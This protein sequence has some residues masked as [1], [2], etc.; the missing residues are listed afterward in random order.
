VAAYRNQVVADTAKELLDLKKIVPGITLDLRY[1]T[2]NNFTKTIL[3]KTAP[4]TYM[5]T[6]PARTLARIQAQLRLKNYGIKVFD[7]YRPHAATRLMWELVKDERYVASPVKGSNH[8][9]G[10]AIDMTLVDLKTG[11]ELDMGTG[12]DNFTDTAHHSFTG[13]S[14]QVL[15]NRRYLKSIME[16]NGFKAFDTEWWHYSWPN[17]RNYEILDLDFR[18]LR[19]VIR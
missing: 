5:R 4:T 13:L 9:R 16:A 15:E 14:A 8:N 7:A 6:Q 2:R 17:D 11:K 1:A 12:F 3:Y 19:K 10:L 18:V